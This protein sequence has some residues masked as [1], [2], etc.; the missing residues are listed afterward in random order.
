MRIPP[1]VGSIT[2]SN[3]KVAPGSRVIDA[4]RT[5]GWTRVRRNDPA[6]APRALLLPLEPTSV[7]HRLLAGGGLGAVLKA[8]PHVADPTSHRQF[9]LTPDP[10]KSNQVGQ[11]SG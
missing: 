8:P 10:S 3:C 4:N 6:G 1:S 7:P 5:L 2:C 9:K 11:R